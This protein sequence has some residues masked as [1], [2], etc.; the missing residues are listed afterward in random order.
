MSR[1]TLAMN[2][3]L[4]RMAGRRGNAIVE[5]ALVMPILAGAAVF[6]ADIGAATYRSMTLKSATRAGAEYLLRTGDTAGLQAVVAAAANRDVTAISV[7]ATKFCVCGTTTV[8]CSAS[9]G[10]GA[11][12][13]LWTVG[14]SE[15]YAPVIAPL[16]GNGQ[17]TRML[18][19]Q[20]TFRVK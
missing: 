2:T 1:G 3:L 5:L 15:P 4:R 14:V 19:A 12:Q 18:T 7:T 8:T 9:C 6:V 17:D 20:A 11:L 10:E 13:T 16:G